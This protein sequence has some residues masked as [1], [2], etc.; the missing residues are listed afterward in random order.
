VTPVDFAALDRSIAEAPDDRVAAGAD[1]EVH[2]ALRARMD[3]EVRWAYTLGV[4]L[5]AGLVVAAAEDLDEVV[6]G[7]AAALMA[8][9]FVHITRMVRLERVEQAHLKVCPREVAS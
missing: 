3:R 7:T 1:D 2:D 6:Y 9:L 8:G 5:V 4:P